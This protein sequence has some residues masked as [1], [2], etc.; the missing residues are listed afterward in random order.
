M[1]IVSEDKSPHDVCRLYGSSMCY[2]SRGDEMKDAKERESRVDDAGSS[3]TEP[4]GLPWA[5][6]MMHVKLQEQ[7]LFLYHCQSHSQP[8][9]IPSNPITMSQAT[10]QYVHHA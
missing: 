6:C 1:G 3:R 7:K 10:S 8:V 5:K 4:A 9:T 2:S